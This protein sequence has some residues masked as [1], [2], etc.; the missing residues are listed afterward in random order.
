VTQLIAL[1]AGGCLAAF[2]LSWGAIKCAKR[3]ELGIDRAPSRRRIHRN[4][5]PRLGGIPIFFGFTLAVAW[6]HAGPES[7]RHAFSLASLW[8]LTLPIFAVGLL[9]DLTGRAS[10]GLR[11]GVSLLCAAMAATLFGMTLHSVQFAYIDVWLGSS[12][13]VAVVFS[14]VA[15]GGVPHAFNII[16]GCN[17]L[18]GSIAMAA[19]ASLGIV[20]GAVGDMEIAQVC[21]LTTGAVV[22][23]MFWN[24]PLGR[25]FLGD[26]GAYVLGFIIAELS[27]LLLLRNPGVSPWFPMMLVI[28]P[29]WETLFSIGRRS[30]AGLGKI[31]QADCNHLHQKIYLSV[32]TRLIRYHLPQRKLIANSLASVP[33]GLWALFSAA[34]ATR[35]FDDTLMLKL[36]CAGFALAYCLAYSLLEAPRR[37]S[38]TPAAQELPSTTGL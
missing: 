38:A 29:V 9:E 13:V 33:F 35:Y 18:A 24:F 6:I 4:S 15:L 22:G 34:F 28:Y 16:D 21:W 3:F 10:I 17:G 31:M 8:W 11:L 20:A 26:A 32:S 7:S 27:V 5:V 25:I 19:L 2:V 30:A 23:F 14:T 1:L 36:G 37:R 12:A